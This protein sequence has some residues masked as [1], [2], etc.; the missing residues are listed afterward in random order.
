MLSV[1]P[2]LA[3]GRSRAS[4][5]RGE[6][7]MMR[8]LRILALSLSA[9]VA[10]GA[11][12]ASGASAFEFHSDSSTGNTILEGVQTGNHV[13][14]AAGNEITCTSA[15]FKG[16]QT[17]NT[18]ERITATAEYSGCTVEVFGLFKVSAE[19][20]MNGCAYEFNTHT[21]VSIVNNGMK[22]CTE[23]PI[24]YSSSVLGIGIDVTVGPQSAFGF[25]GYDGTM[26]VTN[27]TVT[28]TPNLTGIT[29]K[30]AGFGCSP[31]G[32]FANGK[33]K[34]GPTKVQGFTDNSGTK[35]AP[36]PIWVS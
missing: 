20:T 28:V 13:F 21:G 8:K 34:S 17:G 35:G 14:E 36:T 19:V 27:G 30:C 2:A 31:E 11:I 7:K 29:G 15:K 16:T 12:A 5:T 32:V 1:S 4:P 18:A 9:L 33:Y 3:L 24:T 23:H 26:T 6:I 22:S 10:I 25:V